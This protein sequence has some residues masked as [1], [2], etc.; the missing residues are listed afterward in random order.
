M[1]D[2]FKGILYN[3]WNEPRHFFFWLMML[4]LGGF[5]AVVV[6]FVAVNSSL[7]GPMQALAF[8]ALGCALCFAISLPALA[9]SR[10]SNPIMVVLTRSMRM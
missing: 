9:I 1:N 3:A 7:T 6:G 5:A 8:V 4:S 10:R 2:K